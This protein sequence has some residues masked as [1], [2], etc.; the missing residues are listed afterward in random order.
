MQEVVER[1]GELLCELQSPDFYQR[2]EAVKELGTYQADEAVAGLIMALEDGDLGIRELAAEYLVKMSGETTTQL[3]VRFLANEDI[4]TR[5]LAS[6]I[7]VKIG[8]DA[9]P[10]ILENITCDDHDVRKFLVDVVGMIKDERAIE[11]LCQRLW[12]ENPNVVCSAAEALGEIGSVEAVPHLIAVCD[13]VEDAKLQTIEAL[14]KIGDPKSLDKLYELLGSDDPMILFV[15]LE[16]IGQ[17][18]CIDSVTELKKFLDIEDTSLAESAMGAIIT[19]YNKNEGRIDPDLPLEKFTGFLFDGIKSHND[20]ITDFTLDRLSHWFGSDV[21]QGLLDVIDHVS[22]DRLRRIQE[23]LGEVGHAAGKM[24]VKKMGDATKPTRLKLLD[25]LKYIVDDDIAEDISAYANDPDP[26][27][28]QRVAH[29]LGI[30]GDLKSV[31]RLKEM[32]KDSNGHVRAAAYGALGWLGGESD[33]K[34]IFPGLDDNYSDVR[35][36]AVGALLVIGGESVINKFTD[37]LNNQT[38]ERQ[39]LAVTALGW[40]GEDATVKPLVAAINHPDAGVRKSA[41]SAL[42]RMSHISDVEPILLA[43][44]DENSAVRKAAV[45]AVITIKGADSVQEIRP[46]LDDPDVWVRY[47]TITTIGELGR[48][49]FTDFLMPYLEDESDII[50][51]AVVKTMAMLGERRAVPALNRLTSERNKDLV[52]AAEMALT[53]IE[54]GR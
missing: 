16:A 19:I 12:D 46:L 6:E 38:T 40:M 35:E 41:I 15:S 7:L 10:A 20:E 9:V 53:S 25:L 21:I 5:N 45:T 1:I 47:H 33:L 29:L 4:G 27:I 30:S 48:L 3:L 17:I 2:E 42:S 31:P 37:D 44:T 50:K 28:R 43:L 13:K 8:R 24:I 22:E 39:R 51:I 32:T 26:E 23:I 14:G 11:P 52:D 34:D 18:G 54:R 49:E 36:A